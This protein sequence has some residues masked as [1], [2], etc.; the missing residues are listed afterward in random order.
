MNERIA[1]ALE[2][3][4]EQQ[5]IANLLTLADKGYL[6]YEALAEMGN[7][8]FYS[9]LAVTTSIPASPSESEDE[10]VTMRPEI[11]AAL[12]LRSNDETVAPAMVDLFLVKGKSE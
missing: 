4:V 7:E 10:R 11:A 6:S 12:G 3:L 8:A 1:E 5:R 9:G 2:A